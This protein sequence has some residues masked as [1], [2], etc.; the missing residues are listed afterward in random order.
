[1]ARSS[2][3]SQRGRWSSHRTRI[4]AVPEC[5]SEIQFPCYGQAGPLVL[6]ELMR[7]MTSSRTQ[8]LNPFKRVA[9]YSIKY[10]RM[11]CRFPWTQLDNHFLRCLVMQTLLDATPREN[12][13]WEVSRC[14]VANS[15]KR[16]PRLWES[17][18]WAV[19][20]P[21]W[22]LWWG[23][24][25]MVWDCSHFWT[26]SVCVVMWQPDLT[27]PQQSGWST[28]SDCEKFWHLSVGDLWVQHHAR[29][30]TIPVSKM[31]GLD[32]KSD[33][34]FKYLGLEPLLRHTKTCNWVPVVDD[35]KSWLLPLG[36]AS[37]RR[38]FRGSSRTR[39]QH[40]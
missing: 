24:Q 34:Q 4:E 40:P 17:W 30:G 8:D 12:P 25:H 2:G 13:Q 16:G 9:R 20:S 37:S 26:T 11:T 21:N 33:A 18:P 23:Q 19:E 6:K 29:S 7:K 14:G 22:R 38:R 27:Q 1:M 31:S 15:W 39:S 3:R 36:A 35:D 5:S 28:G 32:N 10:P